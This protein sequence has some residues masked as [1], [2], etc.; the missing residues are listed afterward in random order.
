MKLLQLCK[1]ILKWKIRILAVWTLKRYKPTV[2]G[3]TGSAGKTSTKEAIFAVLKKEYVCR[4]NVKNF[5]NELGLPLTILGDYQES[6]RFFFWFKVIWQGF[7]RLIIKNKNYPEVLILEMAADRPGD[8][9][10]LAS[11]AKPKIGVITAIGDIPVHVEFYSSPEAVAREKG[12]L[13]EALPEDGF[14]ILNFDDERVWELKNKTRAKVLSFGFN[15]GAD[16]QIGNMEHRLENGRPEGIAF[17]VQYGGSFVPV[18]LN[19]TFGKPQAYSAAA[20]IS[21]GIM[22]GLHLVEISDALSEYEAPEGRMKLI[23]GV[24]KTLILDDSYNASPLSM[25]ASLETLKSLPAKRRIAILA[26]MLE[27]GEYAEEAHRNIGKIASEIVDH[28]FC[29]G[30]RS[31]FMAESA[32]KAGL[33]S[34]KVQV[35][36]TSESAMKMI[37]KELKQGDLILVKG[38][39]AMELDKVLEEIRMM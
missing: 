26:D 39:H 12:R 11:L 32:L 37:E 18:R 7:W 9:K 22:F 28:L 16:V 3:I 23:D 2:I 30:P 25:A 17:K 29:I 20:A 14:A 21:V 1:K 36:D 6:G 19:K 15:K 10:Y 27:I 4:R 13:I 35:F 38:S 34:K 5:N 31:H 24:K 8:I 33:D